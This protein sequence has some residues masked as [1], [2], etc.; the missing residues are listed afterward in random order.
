M[1]GSLGVYMFPDKEVVVHRDMPA[2]DM[3]R[4]IQALLKEAEALRKESR[5]FW[6]R[7]E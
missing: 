1:K 5:E 2:E 4:V 7:Y 6:E 3:W